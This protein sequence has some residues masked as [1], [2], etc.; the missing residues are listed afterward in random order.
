MSSNHSK[1][2]IHPNRSP[3]FVKQLLPITSSP[4]SLAITNLISVSLALPILFMSYKWDY[5]T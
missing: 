2:F 5:T 4:F 1:L 3:I